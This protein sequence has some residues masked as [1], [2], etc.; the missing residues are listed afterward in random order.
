MKRFAR[1][2]IH[3]A[4]L[5]L[6]LTSCAQPEQS[7]DITAALAD[8]P[9]KLADITAAHTDIPVPSVWSDPGTGYR[10]TFQSNAVI[11]YERDSKE[12]RA[13][14]KIKNG[15]L[16]IHFEDQ[17]MQ[18]VP[19]K[20]ENDKLVITWNSDMTSYLSM[21]ESPEYIL[22]LDGKTGKT[23]KPYTAYQ[24]KFPYRFIK[25]SY[26]AY[27]IAH[28]PANT[29]AKIRMLEDSTD[30]LHA[31]YL[32]EQANLMHML[33]NGG[34][35]SE[36]L[37]VSLRE[38]SVESMNWIWDFIPFLTP[39]GEVAV[40]LRLSKNI[41]SVY[42][43][44]YYKGGSWTEPETVFTLPDREMSGNY[45]AP[46]FD[47]HGVLHIVHDRSCIEDAGRSGIY[48]N[49]IQLAGI[50][51]NKY[52]DGLPPGIGKELRLISLHSGPDDILYLNG[53]TE[54]GDSI[55]DPGN[56]Q[57]TWIKTFKYVYSVSRD[58][59]KT[60]KGP[61]TAYKG[62]INIQAIGNVFDMQGK[63]TVMIYNPGSGINNIPALLLIYT[64]E[65][66]KSTVNSFFDRKELERKQYV[67]KDERYMPPEFYVPDFQQMQTDTGSLL[68]FSGRG[69][70]TSLSLLSHV[71]LQSDGTMQIADTNVPFDMNNMLL[72]ENG[73]VAFYGAEYSTSNDPNHKDVM[74]KLYVFN[75]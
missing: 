13:A 25:E 50:S 67:E 35:W 64:G 71:V 68:H 70:A 18:D 56:T 75:N 63:R 62:I 59:G 32:D 36:P 7:P 14:Y 30:R 47:S 51:K 58:G 24:D 11:Y 74:Y 55:R 17:T 33:L 16:I 65:D 37:A 69:T 31:F 26:A 8:N 45:F 10:L 19:Y 73:K 28:I 6:L 54:D 53:F 20:I 60:W 66:G 48:L 43:I 3:F 2:L 29:G 1:L 46:F 41:K 34:G 27:P 9:A 52:F 57:E 72:L 61:Y 40:I 22:G 21:V 49:D 12:R 42:A 39:S 23:E 4:L 15:R 44:T 5:F 38:D